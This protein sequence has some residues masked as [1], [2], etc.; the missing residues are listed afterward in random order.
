MELEVDVSKE[1]L[2]NI[3]NRLNLKIY[4]L[5]LDLFFH[6][7]TFISYLI[8]SYLSSCHDK[9]IYLQFFY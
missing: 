9:N 3:P 4:L 5:E 2:F 7:F 1:Y 8:S 6:Y